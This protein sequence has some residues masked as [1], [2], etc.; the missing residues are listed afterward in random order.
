MCASF[1]RDLICYVQD[2]LPQWIYDS[3]KY[4]GA[5]NGWTVDA[6]NSPNYRME[7]KL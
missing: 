3:N 7:P 5:L 4:S 6:V 2:F 1:V